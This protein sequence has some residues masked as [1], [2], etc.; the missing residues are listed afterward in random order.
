[1]SKSKFEV[2]VIEVVHHRA[3]VMADNAQ[4]AE[5]LALYAGDENVEWVEVERRQDKHH[6]REAME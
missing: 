4:D 1:M 2:T 5:R 3:T 6:V